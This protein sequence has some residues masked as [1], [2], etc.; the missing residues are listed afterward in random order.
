MKAKDI[1]ELTE[2][3]KLLVKANNFM[4]IQFG[5]SNSFVVPFIDGIT[6]AKHFVHA[7][8]YKDDYNDQKS[9]IIPIGS[10]EVTF[11]VM[12][13]EQYLRYKTRALIHGNG[14]GNDSK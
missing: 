4:V 1:V 12:A 11:T 6:I 13:E 5:Y 2:E 10:K 8:F 3:K 7:E 14:D 9:K